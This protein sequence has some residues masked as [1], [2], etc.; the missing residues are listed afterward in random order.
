EA[1]P[2]PD[3]KALETALAD[4]VII[5]HQ[6]KVA[7]GHAAVFGAVAR[8]RQL[9]DQEPSSIILVAAADS[10]ITV[11]VLRWLDGQERLKAAYAPKGFIPG[12]AAG[13][14]VL[15]KERG[16]S[17]NKVRRWARCHEVATTHESVAI[18]AEEPCLGAGL[19]DA[20]QGALDKAGVG[21]GDIGAV[22]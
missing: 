19:T 8:A 2:A 4:R 17:L 9:L 18:D 13:C 16:K 7:G 11:P 12:E 15:E 5:T 3:G 1:A 21:P 6:E 20:L 14:L 10:L 22:L